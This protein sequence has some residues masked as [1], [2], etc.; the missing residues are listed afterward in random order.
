METTIEGDVGLVIVPGPVQ[1]YVTPVVVVAPVK[2]A[3]GIKQLKTQ[4]DVAVTPTG[5]LMSWVTVTEALVVQPEDVL[6][7]VKV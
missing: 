1:R 5:A 2:V 4:L 3:V 7:T 6:V